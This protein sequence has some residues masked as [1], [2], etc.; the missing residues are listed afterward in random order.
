VLESKSRVRDQ[1][2]DPQ[3]RAGADRLLKL[4]ASYRDNEDLILVGAYQKG[5]D[6]RVDTALRLRDPLLGFLQQR[7]DEYTAL[8]ATRMSL[9]NLARQA[10]GGAAC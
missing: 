2:S 8:A 6:P 9:V 3:H 7:P 1:V 10:D 5:S 4:E